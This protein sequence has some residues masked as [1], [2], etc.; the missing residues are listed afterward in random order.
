[1]I[2]AHEQQQY[3]EGKSANVSLSLQAYGL[4]NKDL[5]QAKLVLPRQ[6]A[7]HWVLYGRHEP[8]RLY[9]AGASATATVWPKVH[10][11][12]RNTSS[13]VAVDVS[14]IA[15]VVTTCVRT[16]THLSYLAECLL[17]IRRIYPHVHI[18]VLNDNSLLDITETV[19]PMRVQVVPSL[20]V[21]G[22]E[23]NPYLFMWDP[24]C[25]H[26]KLVYIHDTVFLKR[27]ID[28]FLVRANDIDF[29]WYCD[30]A[31]YADTFVPENA[32]I[33]AQLH[34][35]CSN[36]K[37]S[38]GTLIHLIKANRVRFTVKFGAMAVFTRQF[39]DKVDTVTNLKSVSHLFSKRIHRCLFERILSYLVLFIHGHDTPPRDALCGHIL[40]HPRANRN[41]SIHLPPSSY[42]QPLV[43]VWQG[44]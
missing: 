31:Q 35:Y 18:Y 38:L 20:V 15:F 21:G 8:F 17:H 13:S 44:R 4:L 22:G 10:A 40:H 3:R 32:A 41:T 16:Q 7:T 29:M 28:A 25:L 14:K 5:Q 33:L 39:M 23:I 27:N 37:V 42:K 43:K 24:R 6:L 9:A 26:D 2:N 30:S 19:R 12:L 34:F 36:M 1:M 11:Y